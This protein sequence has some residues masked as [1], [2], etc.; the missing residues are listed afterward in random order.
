MFFPEPVPG[1]WYR[2]LVAAGLFFWAFSTIA[3]T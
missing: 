2:A 1:R 3:I